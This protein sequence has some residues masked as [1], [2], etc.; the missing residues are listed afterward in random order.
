MFELLGLLFILSL[1][2]LFAI[3]Y[4]W[5]GEGFLTSVIVVLLVIVAMLFKNR[6]PTHPD[7]DG[8]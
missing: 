1:I 5:E 7:S 6:K 4:K 2:N 8:Y 3:K